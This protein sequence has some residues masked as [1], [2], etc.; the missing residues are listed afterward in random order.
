MN[1]AEVFRAR[2]H[3]STGFS[4]CSSVHLSHSKPA[5]G[6]NFR[7]QVAPRT[8]MFLPAVLPLWQIQSYYFTLLPHR[9]TAYLSGFYTGAGDVFFGIA[10]ILGDKKE[11]VT[12]T[13]WETAWE[14][15]FSRRGVSL[16]VVNVS[17]GQDTQTYM[18]T[19]P[20]LGWIDLK[21]TSS[22]HNQWGRV[23]GTLWGNPD[24]PSRIERPP[25]SQ[26]WQPS[27]ESRP[28]LIR[29]DPMKH[30]RIGAH[31]FRTPTMVSAQSQPWSHLFF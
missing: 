20:P 28:S 24:G 2:L 12:V 5:A 30:T 8:S 15:G 23:K 3:T 27:V 29:R 9:H 4:S 31:R 1:A 26:F 7:R 10:F 22:G 11:R 25:L 17:K 16:G 6:N 13:C 19:F 18:Q 14:Q 21:T